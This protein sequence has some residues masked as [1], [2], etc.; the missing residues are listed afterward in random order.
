MKIQVSAVSIISHVK[1]EINGGTML[2]LKL[3]FNGSEMTCFQAHFSL[4]STTYEILV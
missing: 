3:F 1:N 4:A 2:I